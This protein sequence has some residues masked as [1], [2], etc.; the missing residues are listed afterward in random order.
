MSHLSRMSLYELNKRNAEE[1]N[2]GNEKGAMAPP[3]EAAISRNLEKKCETQSK[4]ESKISRSVYQSNQSGLQD[5]KS[6]LGLGG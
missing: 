1:M 3:S 6:K 2:E 5:F 4:A